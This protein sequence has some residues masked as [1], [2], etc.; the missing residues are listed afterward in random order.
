MKLSHSTLSFIQHITLDSILNIKAND[1]LLKYKITMAVDDTLDIV[2]VDDNNI[3][4]DG[5]YSNLEDL[6]DHLVIDVAS[7]IIVELF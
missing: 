4:Y 6:K 2:S 1:E 7:G 5:S 3:F